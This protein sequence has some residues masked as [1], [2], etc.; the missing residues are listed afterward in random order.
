MCLGQSLG[1]KWWQAANE[2]VMIY[3]EQRISERAAGCWLINSI[4]ELIVWAWSA[5]HHHQQLHISSHIVHALYG[6]NREQTRKILR[7]YLQLWSTIAIWETDIY[8]APSHIILADHFSIFHTGSEVTS[9][10]GAQGYDFFVQWNFP[11][12][13]RTTALIRHHGIHM[14]YMDLLFLCWK[15]RMRVIDSFLLELDLSVTSKPRFSYS[16]PFRIT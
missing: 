4:L 16:F 8:L 11:S 12:V 2:I 1:C 3:R 5:V 13:I 10:A 7:Y 15:G 9:L 6:Y 14:S